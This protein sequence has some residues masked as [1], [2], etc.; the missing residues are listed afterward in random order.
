MK[1]IL[2][3]FFLIASNYATFGQ[4]KNLNN[5]EFIIV[6]ERFDFL[7]QDDQYQTSSLTKFLLE[8]NGFVVL[9]DSEAYPRALKDNPCKGATAVVV[10]KSSLFKT[11]VIIELRDCFNKLIYTSA[12]G[13]S[14]LKDYKK[15]FQEAIR[16]A[17]ANMN[18]VTYEAL[19]T[20]SRVEVENERS[21]EVPVVQEKVTTVK[22]VPERTI[23]PSSVK[24]KEVAENKNL[25]AV[26]LLYAQPKE[27]GFQLVDAQP[28]VV[29]VILNTHVKGVFILKDKNGILY[30][31]GERW[32]A[33]FYEEGKVVAKK[34]QIKF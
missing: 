21:V 8:K 29:F 9:L 22:F 24:T 2:L 18:D 34:Y 1:N 11:K 26:G 16:K 33:E 17:H 3:L 19:T 12:A 23:S 20:A 6:P 25:E 14:K 15:G 4:E 28:T 30:K 10:D 32:I 27:N 13:G 31:K 5:Y 7:S